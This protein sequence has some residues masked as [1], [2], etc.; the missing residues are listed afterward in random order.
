MFHFEF[1]HLNHISHKERDTYTPC[2]LLNLVPRAFLR[3][4]E[5]EKSPG[6]ELAPAVSVGSLRNR[7][8]RTPYCQTEWKPRNARSNANWPF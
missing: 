5:G 3:Q 8:A 2:V 4:G 7:T 6:K 1:V